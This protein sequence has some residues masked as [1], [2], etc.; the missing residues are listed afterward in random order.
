[1]IAALGGIEDRE[2]PVLATEIGGTRQAVARSI[3]QVATCGL[4]DITD[5]TLD[6]DFRNRRYE[7]HPVM[8]ATALVAE[9]SFGSGVTTV[10]VRQLA[11]RFPDHVVPLTDAAIK[12]CRLGASGADSTARRL[13]REIVNTNVGTLAQRLDLASRLVWFDKSSVEEICISGG[14]RDLAAWQRGCRRAAPR[15]GDAR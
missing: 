14:T 11:S 5:R 1:M 15:C 9:R 6:D 4:I 7:V 3:E 10:D 2:L 13:F 8:L 12:A